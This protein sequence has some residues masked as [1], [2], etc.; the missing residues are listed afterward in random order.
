MRVCVR[1][2]LM[3]PRDTIEDDAWVSVLL[4]RILCRQQNCSKITSFHLRHSPGPPLRG[5]SL[6]LGLD[7]P[8]DL[9]RESE[10]SR[11]RASEMSEESRERA[12]EATR[13]RQWSHQTCSVE[14][15]SSESWACIVVCIIRSGARGTNFCSF[16]S[17][18]L[19]MADALDAIADA[20][21][22][23]HLGLA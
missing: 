21:D 19:T 22:L 9:P 4:S 18:H 5:L 1:V 6:D 7:L 15:C 3:G 14:S 11:E 13:V 10:E 20:L 12:S 23:T 16:A 8:P 17:F 2:Y